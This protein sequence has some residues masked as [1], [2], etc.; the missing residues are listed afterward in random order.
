MMLDILDV[1]VTD[2]LRRLRAT[3]QKRG[4]TIWHGDSTG[5]YWAAH[6]GRM[7]L[8]SGHSA[9]ALTHQIERIQPSR[10]PSRVPAPR[11]FSPWRRPERTHRVNPFR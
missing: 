10:Q 5:Q 2:H 9:Q 11:R 8:V 7:V 3:F 4:W 1:P 6:T